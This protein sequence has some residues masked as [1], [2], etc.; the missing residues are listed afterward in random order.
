MAEV[1]GKAPPFDMSKNELGFSEGKPCTGQKPRGLQDLTPSLSCTAIDISHCPFRKTETSKGFKFSVMSM[2]YLSFES[3]TGQ[4][5][6]KREGIYRKR[7][8]KWEKD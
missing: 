5:I 3:I 8:N 7:I 4:A 1:K 6:T 2:Y